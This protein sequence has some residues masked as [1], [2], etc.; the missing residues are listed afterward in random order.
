MRND[1]N[2]RHHLFWEE[3]NPYQGFLGL[4]KA[5]VAGSEKK[6]ENAFSQACVATT[7]A[8]NIQIR[9]FY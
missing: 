5:R 8:V 7:Y 4:M 6:R 3:S 1:H 9:N 2:N